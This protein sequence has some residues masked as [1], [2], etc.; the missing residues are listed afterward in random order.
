M[1]RLIIFVLLFLNVE[2]FAP[3][4]KSP[5]ASCVHTGVLV[6]PFALAQRQFNP[7]P[8][9]SSKLS[10]ALSITAIHNYSIRFAIVNQNQCALIAYD[11]FRTFDLSWSLGGRYKQEERDL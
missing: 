1:D 4:E 5:P 2:R 3:V 9:I 10:I 7:G 6:L 8:A 11:V